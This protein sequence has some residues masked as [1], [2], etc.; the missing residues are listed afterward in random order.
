MVRSPIPPRADSQTR[1]RF[2]PQER[3]RHGT[4]LGDHVV[5]RDA[6]GS[7][8]GPN[9]EQK[10]QAVQRE[11]P[12]V[13]GRRARGCEDVHAIRWRAASHGRETLPNGSQEMGFKF[14]KSARLDRV[15]LAGL[16]RFPLAR[17]RAEDA[18]LCRPRDRIVL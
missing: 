7:T 13:V 18:T 16:P 17:A 10:N 8:A 2:V 12:V 5:L 3:R 1:R 15:Q 6:A 11:R 9:L 4:A 14:R